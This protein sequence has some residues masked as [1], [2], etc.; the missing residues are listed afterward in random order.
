MS[1]YWLAESSNLN[2][3]C[4]NCYWMTNIHTW[5]P[6]SLY[7]RGR[8]SCLRAVLCYKRLFTKACMGC[9]RFFLKERKKCYRSDFNLIALLYSLLFACVSGRFFWSVFGELAL[10]EPWFTS[11]TQYLPRFAL[12]RVQFKKKNTPANSAIKTARTIL[13]SLH[14]PWSKWKAIFI[15]EF[16]N[17][18]PVDFDRSI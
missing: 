2:I 4:N 5:D 6:S 10:C 15:F 16:V 12:S 18:F 8:D 3:N 17:T 7:E 14:D 13:F 1:K 11:F 9:K